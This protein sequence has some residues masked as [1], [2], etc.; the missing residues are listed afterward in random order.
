MFVMNSLI[1]NTILETQLSFDIILIQELPW[2]VICSITNSTSYKED[3]LVR[4]PHYPN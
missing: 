1:I 4:V 2:L 3:E